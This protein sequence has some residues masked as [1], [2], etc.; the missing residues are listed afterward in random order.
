M[1]DQ[2]RRELARE[3]ER[4]REQK[5]MEKH[6]KNAEKEKLKLQNTIQKME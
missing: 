5:E 1:T 2:E 3:A 6:I 4:K